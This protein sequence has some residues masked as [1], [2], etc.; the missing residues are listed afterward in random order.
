VTESGRLAERVLTPDEARVVASW[1]YDPPF[2]VYDLSGDD[3]VAMLLA[4]DERGHG[5]YPVLQGDD[6]V[7][8][9]ACFGA[10]ARVSGQDEHTSTCDV[11]V[12]LA[13]E[14]L[15]EGIATS[16]MPAVVRFAV[17]RFGAKVVRAAVAAFNDR[18]LR[19]CT[20]AGFQR[21]REFVGP[22]GRPFVELELVPGR[23][24]N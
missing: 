18:S 20:S 5:Y 24:A 23:P 11:G 15:S 4:R 12:G 14:R 13:P 16:L 9:F 1:A 22:G 21:V 2:D 7:V 8:G 19:L 3:A 6:V 10:E 17:D